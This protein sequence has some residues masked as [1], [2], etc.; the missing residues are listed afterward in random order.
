MTVGSGPWARGARSSPKTRA[1]PEYV[2]LWRSHLPPAPQNATA[3]AFVIHL[4]QGMRAAFIVTQLSVLFG[5]PFVI[6]GE[7]LW[8]V[9]LCH[10]LYDTVAFI[11][12]ANRSSK[13]SNL[14]DCQ[15]GLGS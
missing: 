1:T 6:S 15:Q 4:C 3:G 13:Y 14:D 7:N 5:V 10:G 9:V 2:E 12:F 8:T 11:R